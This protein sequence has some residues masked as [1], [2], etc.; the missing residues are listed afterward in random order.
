MAAVGLS[1][2]SRKASEKEKGGRDGGAGEGIY[3]SDEG[4]WYSPSSL[5]HCV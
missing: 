4:E 3:D 2:T 5:I 1:L